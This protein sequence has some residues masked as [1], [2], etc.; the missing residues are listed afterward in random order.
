VSDSTLYRLASISL[1]VGA[2]A[3]A[4]ASVVPTPNDLKTSVASGLF[5]MLAVG[6]LVGGVLVVAGLPALYLRQRRESGV[7]GLV[8]MLLILGPAMVLTVGFPFVQTLFFP[9]L[10]SL[11]LSEAQF[12]E[13]PPAFALFFPIANVVV[14]L[15][16]LLFGVATIRARVFPRW[17]AIA[18]MA[19]FV[20]SFAAAFAGPLEIIGE[21]TAMVGIIAF[22]VAL[23]LSAGASR[24]PTP[25]DAITVPKPVV[26]P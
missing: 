19:L 11:P 7:L 17:V 23:W 10:A 5:Y 20:I 22:G 21:A 9:W 3:S 4:I 25:A 26:N 16:G 2:A 18:F 1:V 24:E 6:M 8:G 13:G 12:G 14:T 15:G